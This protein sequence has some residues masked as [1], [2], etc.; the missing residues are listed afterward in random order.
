MAETM[1]V[2]RDYFACL[3]DPKLMPTALKVAIVVGSALFC[4]N[5]G[6]A[7]VRHEMTSERWFSVGLT[8]V[9]PYLVNIHGQF[10]QSRQ[11]YVRKR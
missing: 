6:G 11:A 10:A 3:V 5:H 7:L 4:I 2:V 8:Y 1:Q 9:M